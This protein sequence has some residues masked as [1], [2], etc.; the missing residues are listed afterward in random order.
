MMCVHVYIC[1][2][3]QREQSRQADRQAHR[4]PVRSGAR[5]S[6]SGNDTWQQLGGCALAVLYIHVTTDKSQHLLSRRNH[7]AGATGSSIQDRERR[8]RT[9]PSACPSLSLQ[10][11]LSRQAGTAVM[12]I[13]WAGVKVPTLSVPEVGAKLHGTKWFGLRKRNLDAS[14]SVV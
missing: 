14:L 9:L 5:W 10:C 1:T 7:S 4:V 8:M 12:A 11:S 2:G 13:G 3:V 6:V